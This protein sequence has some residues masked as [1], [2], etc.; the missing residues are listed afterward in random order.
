MHAALCQTAVDPTLFSAEGFVGLVFLVTI[1]LIVSGALVA[2]T[3]TRLV[4]CIAGL[5]VCFTGV[6]GAYY[7]LMAPFVAMMQM[8]IYVGAVSI[9]IA[10]AIMMASPEH[11]DTP[12]KNITRFGGPLGLAIAGMVFSALTMMALT[13]DWRVFPRTG[14]GDIRHLGTVLLTSHSLVFELVS[15]VLL[16]AIIGALVIARRGRR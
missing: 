11:S 7:F 15:I 9:L 2:V 16:V 3:S 5:A 4:R 10:F 12:G 6:A 13:T 1:G 14:S 8:L